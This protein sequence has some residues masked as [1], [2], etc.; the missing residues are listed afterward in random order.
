MRPSVLLLTSVLRVEQ[1]QDFLLSD[2]KFCHDFTTSFR[3][4]S[5]ARYNN[6][7]KFHNLYRERE[8]QNLPG[9]EERN[10]ESLKFFFFWKVKVFSLIKEKGMET[11]PRPKIIY[12]TERTNS[13]PA[14]EKK[15]QTEI[16][17]SPKVLLDSIF[18]LNKEIRWTQ[19]EASLL[20]YGYTLRLRNKAMNY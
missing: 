11:D 18:N 9:G 17:Q 14:K 10:L 13:S 20:F 19:V 16:Q 7:N 2:L 12:Q 3:H 5:T 1:S 4:V 8:I 15:C 6:I